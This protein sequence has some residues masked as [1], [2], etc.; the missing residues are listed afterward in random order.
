LASNT[1]LSVLSE[2]KTLQQNF[3]QL[4]LRELID[5]GTINGSKALGFDKELGS[6]RKGKR[7]GLN[8]ITH[9]DFREMKLT[10]QSEI[11]VVF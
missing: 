1:G 8:L 9:I 3:S 6:L 4:T 7:P 2:M 5:W 11:K 10:S